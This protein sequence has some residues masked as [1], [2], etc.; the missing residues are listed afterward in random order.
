MEESE[1][2][3]EQCAFPGSVSTN[4]ADLLALIDSQ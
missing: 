4:E 3:P 2:A 1:R